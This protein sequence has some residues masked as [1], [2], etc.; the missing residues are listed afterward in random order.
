[1]KAAN[2]VA[3]AA[4]LADEIRYLDIARC[5]E[6]AMEAHERDGVQRVESLE[7]LE[8]IDRWARRTA[9]EWARAHAR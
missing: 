6:V 3:V 9:E 4:F 5:V 1:M 2:E 8:K 7:Q